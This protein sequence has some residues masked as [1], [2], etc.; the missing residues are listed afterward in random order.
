MKDLSFV[1]K[2]CN[3]IFIEG[4]KNCKFFTISS[5][6]YKFRKW[7]KRL[8]KEWAKRLRVGGRNDSRN[9]GRNDS[10]A[11]RLMAKRL[12]ANGKVGE[13]TRY[14]RSGVRHST[15]EPPRSPAMICNVLDKKLSWDTSWQNQQND[16][17]PSESQISLGIRPVWSE[18]LLCVERVAKDPSFLHAESEDSDQTGRMPRLISVFVGRTV[19][20]CP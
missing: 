17:A 14:P 8:N 6:K 18:S 7:A 15:T 2:K 5:I 13:T 9:G 11:K 4:N 3:K 1:L 20:L 12:R 19:I 10:G 16:C